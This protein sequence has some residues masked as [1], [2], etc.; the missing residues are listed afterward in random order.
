MTSRAELSST[1]GLC[2]TCVNM[3]IIRSD[4]GSVFYQCLLSN[5][6]PE[7]AKYP[8]LPVLRCAGWKRATPS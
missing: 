6:N 5:K 1:V 8:R 3:K 7:F 2:A 4:R